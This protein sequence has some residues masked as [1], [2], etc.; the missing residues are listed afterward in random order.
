[1]TALLNNLRES[2]QARAATLELAFSYFSE[3]ESP[4]TKTKSLM[5]YPARLTCC[6]SD[7]TDVVTSVDIPVSTLCPCSQ[8]TSNYGAHSQRCTIS[9]SARLSSFP[10]LDRLIHLAEQSASSEIFPLLQR[11]D[12]K[13]V[14]EKLYDT[15]MSAG[16]VAEKL[17][18]RLNDAADISWYSLEILNQESIHQYDTVV[19]ISG[20]AQTT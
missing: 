12:E 15:P 6:C 19:A 4:I 7:T 8:A 11:P 5:A 3:K 17:T 1:I 9:I 2:F 20:P 18:A 16:D 14:T 10:G 13:A